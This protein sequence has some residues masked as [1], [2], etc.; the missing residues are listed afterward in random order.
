MS[1][2]EDV[3]S[4]FAEVRFSAEFF[5]ATEEFEEE[6][7][8]LFQAIGDALRFDE[9]YSLEEAMALPRSTVLSENAE[10]RFIE[11]RA[12]LAHKSPKHFGHLAEPAP[13]Q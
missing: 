11:W 4:V 3:A 5:G 8:H 6:N 12:F 13:K 7:E 2:L 9:G 10:A 1:K